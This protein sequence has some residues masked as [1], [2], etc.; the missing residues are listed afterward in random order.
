VRP[1]D[2]PL[3]GSRVE[4]IRAGQGAANDKA[5]MSGP[6]APG[7]FLN[8]DRGRSV[9][10]PGEIRGLISTRGRV[11]EGLGVLEAEQLR[12]EVL[13]HVQHSLPLDFAAHDKPKRMPS[14]AQSRITD[15][16]MKR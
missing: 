1:C 12:A 5:R 15:Q 6:R 16:T 3:V 2:V 10:G 14:R 7:I 8:S 13:S 4:G 11:C 9:R